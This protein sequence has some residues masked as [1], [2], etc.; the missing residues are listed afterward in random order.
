MTRLLRCGKDLT[1][2][3][4]SHCTWK[5]DIFDRRWGWCY[6]HLRLSETRSSRGWKRLITVPK[7]LVEWQSGWKPV[8]IVHP[9]DILSR[10]GSVKEEKVSPWRGPVSRKWRVWTRGEIAEF[11]EVFRPKATE[12]AGKRRIEA[13]GNSF[14]QRLLRPVHLWFAS[15]LKR[16][17]MDGTFN[18]TAPR[19]RLIPSSH[20]FSFDLKSATDRWPLLWLPRRESELS[21]IVAE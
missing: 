6:S 10:C 5:V 13:I 1:A 7:T 8:W 19:V 16:I 17:P 15:V 4:L 20:C 21:L 3:S 18:Q 2:A 14:N 11:F 9:I 12:G